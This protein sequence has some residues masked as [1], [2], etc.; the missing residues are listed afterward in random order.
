M[1][2]GACLIFLTEFCLGWI[3]KVDDIPVVM[4][5]SVSITNL[6][7]THPISI[8]NTLNSLYLKGIHRSLSEGHD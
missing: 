6:S 5:G 2:L 3:Q 1:H 7:L 4:K 8:L